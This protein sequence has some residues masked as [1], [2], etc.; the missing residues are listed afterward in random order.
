VE[1]DWS[2]F[3]LEVINF[4]ILV[5]LLKRFLYQPVLNVV[6]QRRQ[7]IEAEL[8]QTAKG[9]AEAEALKQQYEARLADW[10]QEKRDAL[11]EL[12][13][14]VE[15][16]RGKRLQQ[17]DAELQQQQLKHQ[18]RDEQQQNQWRAQ[19]EAEA[20][21]LGSAF[22]ARLLKALSCP[23]LDLH[24]QQ[25]FIDQLAAL[26]EN[27]MR[28]LRQGWQAQGTKIEIISATALDEARQQTIRQALE[29]KLGQRDGQWH[30]RQDEHLIA[31][32][33]VSIGGWM[34]QANLQD[35]LRFFS[36]AAHGG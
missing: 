16:E 28:E 13:Q 10:E 26:P 5:W 2:T 15:Q 19:A 21:Q 8:T 22:A 27:S 18:A 34:L 1:L 36:E 12:E 24:L 6:A 7:K 4:L 20:L 33:R 17:L 9:Q 14:Q 35:E 3:L 29:Q 31:G 30:F 25:L 32:L 23:E 11:D